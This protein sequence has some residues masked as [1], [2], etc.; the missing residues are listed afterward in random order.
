MEGCRLGG[1]YSFSK[2]SDTELMQYRCPVL[3]AG[4]SSNTCPRCPL[5]CDSE[6]GGE[7]TPQPV[8]YT[9][10]HPPRIQSHC[11]RCTIQHPT[12]H[13]VTPFPHHQYGAVPP[14]YRHASYTCV[15]PPPHGGGLSKGRTVWS[16]SLVH[17]MMTMRRNAWVR[18]GSVCLSLSSE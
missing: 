10:T 15:N 18:Y 11:R 4:P 13:T 16:V 14:V 9:P 3:S 1:S 7:P 5:H 12:Q 17:V 6:T 2:V 8:R